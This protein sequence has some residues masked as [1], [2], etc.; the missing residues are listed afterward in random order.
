[1][2]LCEVDVLITQLI[3]SNFTYMPFVGLEK[4]ISN[5]WYLKNINTQMFFVFFNFTHIYLKIPINESILS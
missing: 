5:N 1:M 3:S 2:S 4:Y